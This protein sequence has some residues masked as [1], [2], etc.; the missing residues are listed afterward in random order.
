MSLK[1][2]RAGTAADKEPENGT[3]SLG[4]WNSIGTIENFGTP[5]KIQGGM[6]KKNIARGHNETIPTNH[7]QVDSSLVTSLSE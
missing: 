5:P 2:D 3:A 4:A 6:S 1:L 7:I